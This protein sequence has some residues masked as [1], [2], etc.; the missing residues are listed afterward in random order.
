MCGSSFRGALLILSD[1][2]GIEPGG[3]VLKD[4][5]MSILIM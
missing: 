3:N 4:Q 2:N 1:K 5:V